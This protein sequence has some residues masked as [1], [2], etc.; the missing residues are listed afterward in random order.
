[1]SSSRNTRRIDASTAQ[2]FALLLDAT[3]YPD[4][5]VGAQAITH[6]DDTWPAVGSSF[7]HRIGV[8]LARMPGSTTVAELETDRLFTLRA[9]MGLLGEAEVRFVLEPDGD[10]HT[11]LEIDER[12][13]KGVVRL[14]DRLT[15]PLVPWM[16]WGRNHVSMDQLIE[17]AEGSRPG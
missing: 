17:L 15:G 3:R 1:M 4:W 11:M 10:A 6:V 9:G 14:T 16:L 12:P 5:L 13:A 7:H 8:G 2:V